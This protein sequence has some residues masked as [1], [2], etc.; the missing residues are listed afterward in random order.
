MA[1]IS[2]V[3]AGI[4]TRLLTIAAFDGKVYDKMRGDIT[5]PA[6]IVLPAPA[7]SWSTAPQ[8]APTT[9]N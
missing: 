9:C 4:R 7:H 6:A 2:Q 3:R 8:P 1:T 5:P